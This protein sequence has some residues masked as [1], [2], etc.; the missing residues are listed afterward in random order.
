MLI[1]SA[2][3]LLTLAGG[4]QHGRDLGCLGIIPDGAVLI[5][6]EK[7]AAI[8]TTQELRAAYPQEPLLDAGGRVVLPGLVD[9]H[10]HAIWVGDRLDEFELLTQGMPYDEIM[11]RGG[12]VYATMRETCSAPL[13]RLI[14]QTRPRLVNMFSSG[15][16]TAEVRTGYGQRISTGLRMF[17]A[18]LALDREGP[19][20]LAFTFLG[21]HAI[22]PNYRGRSDEYADLVCT[23]MLDMLKAWWTHYAPYRELPFI[24]V[25]CGSDAFRLEEAHRILSV[26]R[27]QGFPLKVLA[28]DPVTRGNVGLALEM[29]ATSVDHLAGVA[30]QEI[31]SLKKGEVVTVLLPATIFGLGVAVYAQA[32]AIL[33]TGSVLAL[34]SDLNPETTWCE[35]MQFV[36]ALAC[37]YL[38]LTPAQAI[39]AATINAAAAI[40]RA[41]KI[42]SLEPG[43][44]ADLLILSVSD[45]RHLG[46]RFGTNLAQTVI[47]KGRVYPV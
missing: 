6:D 36:I 38:H 9:P 40:Q 14:E 10:T 16:T 4:P 1:H 47:K 25:A 32:Q 45:Y 3:Q 26:A 17:Q 18:L 31:R 13:E 39:A 34:G 7:I 30:P 22:H 43:K 5:R 41:D 21:S 11:A 42:G 8:G 2:S 37:R 15:T 28:A 33:E 29:G 12:G 35:S 20:E 46:Y 19:I 24:D 23:N 27:E 44:Q